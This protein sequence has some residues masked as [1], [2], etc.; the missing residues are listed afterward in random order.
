METEAREERAK[1][2]CGIARRTFLKAA[3]ATGAVLG[4]SGLGLHGYQ[5]GK[6]PMKSPPYFLLSSAAT[7]SS[8]LRAPY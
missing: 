6:D 2:K 4:V 7:G 3:G 1:Q 5:A 8:Y